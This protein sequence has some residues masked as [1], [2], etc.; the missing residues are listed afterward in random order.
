M[1]R[2]A[3]LLGAGV[4]LIVAGFPLSGAEAQ[5]SG[6]WPTY[7][8]NG[9]RTGYNAA[10]TVITPS[11]APSL[12]SLWTDSS[13]SVSAQPVVDNG[14][15][16][17]GSWDGYERA[18]SAATGS[19][20]WSTFIGQTTDAKCDPPTVGVASSATVTTTTIDGTPT[21]VVYVGGG[22]ANFYA[23]NAATGAVIWKTA[24]GTSPSTF[25]WSS[26]LVADGSVYEGISSFGDC[27]LIRGGIAQ[28]DP[29]TGAIQN[30]LYTSPAGCTGASVWGSPT[31]DPN[32]GDIYFGTGNASTSC[33][34][35]GEPLS[36]AFIQTD[37][38]LNL[39]GSW[40]IPAAS[41]IA[42][43]DFGSTPTLF[44]AVIN[45][46]RHQMVGLPNKNGTFYAFDTANVSAGPLWHRQLAFKGNCPE[47]GKSDISSAAWDGSHLFAAGGKGTVAGVTCAAT[48][49]EIRPATGGLIWSD[50]LPTGP[51]L[52]AVSMVPGVELIAA[53]NT[54]YAI[55]AGTGTTLWTYQD[56]NVGSN[57]WGPASVSDGIMYVGN[58]DGNLYAFDTQGP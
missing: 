51:V 57:F 53:G 13:G 10:E 1:P 14:V 11:T 9:A 33:G 46:V 45:G 38:N 23:L 7:L 19:L 27:P 39:R 22:D 12:T 41:Q 20:I 17:Y 30:T 44:S 25:A 2:I 26:P 50:C 54:V 3:R 21:Q 6:D 28:L 55:A 42:D 31:V 32:T 58:Q 35:V 48:A 47:C 29:A 16:Y 49:R 4:V 15:V 37:S 52:A 24:L 56:T 43:G 8:N 18:V 5:P 36:D 34:S 40:Q